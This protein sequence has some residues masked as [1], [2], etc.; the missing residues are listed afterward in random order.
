MGGILERM[1]ASTLGRAASAA[2]RA[3]WT[4][5]R[6]HTFPA[7]WMSLAAGLAAAVNPH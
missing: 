1:N 6:A 5:R 7:L 3:A 2:V 4:G